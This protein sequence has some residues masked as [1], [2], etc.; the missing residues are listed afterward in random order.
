MSTTNADSLLRESAFVF[1]RLS[2]CW[3]SLSPRWFPRRRGEARLSPAEAA[4]MNVGRSRLTFPRCDPSTLR[5]F[6]SSTS[7]VPAVLWPGMGSGR[8]WRKAAKAATPPK[9]PDPSRL[10]VHG[11]HWLRA[12]DH[13]GDGADPHGPGGHPAPRTRPQGRIPHLPRPTLTV[14]RKNR[15]VKTPRSPRMRSSHFSIEECEAPFLVD[16]NLHSQ[17]FLAHSTGSL[18]IETQPSRKNAR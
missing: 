3:L 8:T 17:F 11:Q 9:R 12:S 6:D 5:L 10:H 15:I 7:W 2:R 1:Q 16:G 18:W 4:T 14:S 13:L